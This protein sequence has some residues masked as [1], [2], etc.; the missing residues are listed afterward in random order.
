MSK[1]YPRKDLAGQTPAAW[2]SIFLKGKFSLCN[3]EKF[4][5]L[6]FEICTDYFC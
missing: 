5:L 4:G 6:R 2:R 1:P 3:A